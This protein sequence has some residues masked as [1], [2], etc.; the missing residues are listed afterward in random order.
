ML[1]VWWFPEYSPQE[2]IV[3]DDIKATIEKTYRSFGY[4]HIATPAVE[5][6]EVLLKWWES[7]SKE[8]FGLYWMASGAEDLKWYGLRF[9]LTIPFTRY[10]LDHQGELVFPF[11]RYQVQPVWRGER[12]QRWRYRQFFQADMDAIWRQETDEAKYLFLDAE[13]IYALRETLEKIRVKYL[14]N[15]QFKTHINNRNILG[16]L[17]SSLTDDTDTIT[18]LWKLFDNYYKIGAEKFSTDLEEL[19]G[20][21]KASVVQQFVITSIDDLT[22]NFVDNDEFTKW[23]RE[24][25][26]VFAGLRLLNTDLWDVFVYDPF[27]VRGLDYYTGTVFENLIVDDIAMGS[28]CSWGRYANLTQSLDP[29][30]QRFDG[31]GWSIGLSRLFALVAERIK[32][33]NTRKQGYLFLNFAET[34]P[35]IIEA[36]QKMKAKGGTVEIYPGNDKLKKQF[37]YADKLWIK[38]VVIIWGDE[39][40]NKT[41][42]VKNLETWEEKE[43]PMSSLETLPTNE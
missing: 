41:F 9:D 16:G 38:N 11:K 42:K 22:E 8:V 7:A 34:F 23:V 20:P 14:S 12:A 39:V 17:F 25:K 30:S 28:V 1:K 5:R 36:A 10:V 21:K 31:V 24:L 37:S 35:T 27:I 2:Q 18:K 4:L 33:L 6:N 26:E 15:K 43:W 29:K 32:N 13:L 40:L 3:F 19:L